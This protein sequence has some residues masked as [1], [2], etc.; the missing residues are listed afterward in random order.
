MVCRSCVHH[1]PFVHQGQMVKLPEDGVAWLVDGEDHS[2]TSSGQPGHTEARLLTST[3]FQKK[4]K[5]TKTAVD[6]EDA[7]D[8]WGII[9]GCSKLS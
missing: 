5:N 4:K 1:L 2:L 7:A 6:G 9:N 8:L 3:L